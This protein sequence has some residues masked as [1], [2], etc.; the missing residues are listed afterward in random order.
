VTRLQHIAT[1]T[2]L[3]VASFS[4]VY[5]WRHKLGV[6]SDKSAAV[7]SARVVAEPSPEPVV[8]RG[9]GDDAM[10]LCPAV[11]EAEE[12]E[13]KIAAHIDRPTASPFD[14]TPSA[15][16][17]AAVERVAD[18]L[19]R[20]GRSEIGVNCDEYPCLVVTEYVGAEELDSLVEQ[21][22]SELGETAELDTVRMAIASAGG[23]KR[24]L[25]GIATLP[26]GVKADA[27]MRRAIQ[28]RLISEI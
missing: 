20:S 2:V 13:A 5:A 24:E 3:A 6:E 4:A 15:F 1:C 8:H 16:Q 12:L 25:V 18:A 21:I 7:T 17:P 22:A 27:D 11:G 26:S 14:G 19:R 23:E 9:H 28:R 10:D